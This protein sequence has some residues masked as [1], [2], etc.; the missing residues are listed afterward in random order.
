M[1][2]L[3]NDNLTGL[4]TEEVKNQVLSDGGICVTGRK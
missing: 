2:D 4:A 3:I 1:Q